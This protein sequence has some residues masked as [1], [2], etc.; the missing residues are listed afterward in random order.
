MKI[1][2]I[3]KRYRLSI[4]ACCMIMAIVCCLS[5]CIFFDNILQPTRVVAG[6][7]ANFTLSVRMKPNE[8]IN[9]TH[10]VF[11]F[12]VPSLWTQAQNAS[13]TYTSNK[14]DGKMIAMPQN[15]IAAGTSNLSWQK[16]L[17]VKY[18]SGNNALN[19]MK[20]LVYETATAYNV[21]AKE[22]AIIGKIHFA[23]R[24]G[25][26]NMAFK[27]AYYIANTA[28]GFERASTNINTSVLNVIGG[29]GPNI[30][31]FEPQLL[32]I[33]PLSGGKDDMLTVTFNANVL[34]NVLNNKFE[35]FFSSKAITNDKSVISRDE[36]SRSLKMVPM[37][38]NSWRITFCPQKFYDPGKQMLD[39]IEYLITDAT[40]KLRAGKNGSGIPLIYKFSR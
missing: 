35:V 32:N 31:F 38:N 39:H 22:P 33:V 29:T 26:Q 27:P 21:K 19:D 9:N 24:T 40:G 6:D 14:G 23:I 36:V 17:T 15:N 20:W 10:F 37:G 13:I 11:A 12:L 18:G 28:N 1:F 2:L 30:N 7:M 3:V 5:S 34:P 25:L 8:D 4:I 16:A